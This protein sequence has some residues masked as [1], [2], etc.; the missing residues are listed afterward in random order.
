MKKFNTGEENHLLVEICRYRNCN[1]PIS[2]LRLKKGALYCCRNHG[3]TENKLQRKEKQER[4]KAKLNQIRKMKREIKAKRH[5]EKYPEFFTTLLQKAKQNYESYG[6]VPFR[7]VW[8]ETRHHNCIPVDDHCMLWYKKKL[9]RA[10][11]KQGYLV[12]FKYKK[13]VVNDKN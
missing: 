12:E 3:L 13:K 2:E 1:K 7:S 4:E 8:E 5:N 11:K 9:E 6:S 10:L